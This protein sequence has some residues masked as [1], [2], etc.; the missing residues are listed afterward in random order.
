MKD[1]IFAAL[2][3]V[4]VGICMAVIFVNNHAE[5]DGMKSYLTEGMCMGMCL[6]VAFS[7]VLHISMGL[8]ASIGMLIGETIGMMIKK[9]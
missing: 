2:P 4:I 5:D 3:F 7:G 9:K 6:G 1:F 8:S